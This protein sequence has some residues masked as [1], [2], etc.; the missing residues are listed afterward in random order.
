MATT[1][2]SAPIVIKPMQLDKVE[3]T[4]EGDTPLIVHAWSSK[5]KRMMLQKQMKKT[6]TAKEAKIPT[7]D[8][9]DSA[10]WLTEKPEHGAT[11]EE[12]QAN[13]NA[14]IEAGAK[15]GFP[16]NGIKTSICYGAMR[17]GLFDK[18]T[19]IKGSMFI[20]G[21]REYSTFDLAE[22]TTPETPTIREDICMVGAMK[23]TADI[24]YRLEYW[25][26]SID[27]LLEY[28]RTGKFS[29]EQIL[30]CIDRGGRYSGLGEWR[31][32]KNGHNGMYHLKA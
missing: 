23:N 15:F 30:N 6:K 17:A 24:R 28:D 7:N 29:L 19:E 12:A 1:K 3:F 25:P 27:L 21:A 14:A 20:V 26:W 22:L 13:F 8:A 18:T 4:I 16:T 10:Y 2:K 11:E 9:I 5:A 31:P 32:E